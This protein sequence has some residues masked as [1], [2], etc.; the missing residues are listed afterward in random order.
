M[1]ISLYTSR[2]VLQALG[3]EDYGIYNVV[4]GFVTMIGFL[5]G[6][7]AS[8]TQRFLSYEIGKPDQ[9]DVQ[10]IFSMSLNIH[11][12]IGLFV[13]FLGETLGMWFLKNQMSIPPTRMNAAVIVLHFSLLSFVVSIISVPF[14]ALIISYEK[15]NIFAWVSILD[16]ILKLAV[17]FM[18]SWFGADKLPLYSFLNLVTVC[19]IFSIYQIYCRINY[20]DSRYKYY[21]NKSL[22]NT[23]LSYTGWNLW[24]NIAAILSS[25]GVNI[26]LNIFFGP[27]VN[28]ARGVAIQVSGALNRFVSNVQVAVNPQII[29]SYASSDL[30]YMH[31]LI[32]SSSKYNFYI[33]L[34]LMI[35]VLNN[36]DLILSIWLHT[37]PQNT[38]VFIELILYNML[39]NSLALPLMTAAQATGKIKKYQIIV[40]SILLLNLPLSYLTLKNGGQPYTVFYIAI[41]LSLLAHLIRIIIVSELI[42]LKIPLYLKNTILPLLLVS[43][44]VSALNTLLNTL[45]TVQFSSSIIGF[46]FSLL[47]S[48]SIAIFTIL[49]LGLNKQERRF[50][51]NLAFKVKGMIRL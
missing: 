31:Q 28:A 44:T 7:M 38:S 26:L 48:I 2:V 24:G 23:M 22:F 29:K 37:V 4:A 41:G 51:I 6:A 21:W 3:V 16:A 5:H 46:I 25:Q 40:G 32:Y 34:V 18:L 11:I 20:Q 27:S 9:K 35:P 36:L 50:L 14:N 8:A 1:A 33:L 42:Q 10:G 30:S 47:T 15:M 39:I 49:V 19:I 13:L 43:I 17:V 12:L 45:L